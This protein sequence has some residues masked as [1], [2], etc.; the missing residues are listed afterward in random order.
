MSAFCSP[1]PHSRQVRYEHSIFL[2][3]HGFGAF[4]E[5]SVLYYDAPKKD[6]IPTQQ[7]TE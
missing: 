4:F 6:I 3:F 2:P 1:I 5:L 7:K